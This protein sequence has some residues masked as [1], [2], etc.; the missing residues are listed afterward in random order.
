MDPTHWEFPQDIK[1]PF[2]PMDNIGIKHVNS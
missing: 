2:K 1:G